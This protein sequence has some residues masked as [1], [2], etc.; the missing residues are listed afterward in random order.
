[1][2]LLKV[3]SLRA[4]DET[5]FEE[6]HLRFGIHGRQVDF[7]RIDLYG[8]AVSLSGLGTMN[9]DGTDLKLDFFAV[10]GRALQWMPPVIDQIPAKF[11]QCLLTIKMRGEIGKVE[12]TKEP[13][14][15]LL[16]PMKEFLERMRKYSTI[17]R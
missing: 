8:N 13:V 14:P 9:I 11:A 12:C 3:L 4:P 2:D 16:E 1:V 5:A 15:V 10:W 17:L 7:N 6:A